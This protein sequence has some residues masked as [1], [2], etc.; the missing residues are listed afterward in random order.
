MQTVWL[1]YSQGPTF[2]YWRN[3]IKDKVQVPQ[4][5]E[6]LNIFS[7]ILDFTQNVS[8]IEDYNLENNI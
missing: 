4:R 8:K 5:N 3:E 1:P 2:D 6:M 7:I